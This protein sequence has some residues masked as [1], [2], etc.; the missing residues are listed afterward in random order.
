[1]AEQAF[2]LEA[3]KGTGIR[4]MLFGEFFTRRRASKGCE[5]SAIFNAVAAAGGAGT[6]ATVG[7]A[8]N[9]VPNV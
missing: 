3:L 7:A 9:A 6:A 4:D 8:A 5:V 1:M 2:F